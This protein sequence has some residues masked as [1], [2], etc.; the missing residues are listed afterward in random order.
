M[1]LACSQSSSLH[2][3]R[4]CWHSTGNR[5]FDITRQRLGDRVHAEVADLAQPLDMVP[6]G[7]IDLAV[8][9]LVLHYIRDWAPVL[10]EVHRC[11]V[12]GGAL[13]FSIHHPI[14]GWLLSDR[15][16]YHRTELI[17]ED[18]DWDG[19]AVTANMYRRPPRHPTAGRP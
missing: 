4:T 11:L 18:W 6:T 1:P 8:A 12:P 9:S 10:T 15:A 3:G 17:S 14:T 2:A 19:Q 16:N 13:V 5:N 7:N